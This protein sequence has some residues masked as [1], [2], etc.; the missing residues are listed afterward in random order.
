MAIFLSAGYLLTLIMNP[1]WPL[2]NC[3]PTRKV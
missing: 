1:L 2:L 3:R